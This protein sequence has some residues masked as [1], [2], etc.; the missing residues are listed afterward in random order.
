MI[1]APITVGSEKHYMGVVVVQN[2]DNNRFYVHEVVS[3]KKKVHNRSRP[4]LLRKNS[5]ASGDAP[6]IISIQQKIA[7]YNSEST[8]ISKREKPLSINELEMVHT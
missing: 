3:I 7:N 6:S 8:N 5:N 4:A 2:K 1:A